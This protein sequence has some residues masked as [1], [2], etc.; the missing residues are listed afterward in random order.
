M[1][2]A[3]TATRTAGP[4]ALNGIWRCGVNWKPHNHVRRTTMPA[5]YTYPGLYVEEVPSGVRPI[6]GVST[7]ETAFINFFSRGPINQAQR[8][9][10]FAD[11][12]RNFGGLDP[13]SESSYAVQQY[14]LN[15]GQV[16]W[17][18]RVGV[19][20]PGTASLTLQTSSPPQNTL[21]VSA[22]NP[23]HWGNRLQIAVIQ[24]SPTQSTFEL[25]VREAIRV[26]GKPPRVVNT[27]NYRNLSMKKGDRA[28]AVDVVN[29]A[30]QLIQL[31]DTG[32]GMLPMSSVPTANGG[33]PDGAFQWLNGGDDG[34]AFDDAGH[35]IDPAGK[36]A[37]AQALVPSDDT[38]KA[39]LYALDRIDPFIFNILCLPTAASLTATTMTSLLTTV[40]NYCA[41]K[42]AFLI[43]DIP[44]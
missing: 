27:E 5:T 16:A 33:A 18:V 2:H 12:E 11:F 3:I 32:L 26:P 35:L 37:M 22:A 13:R 20:D 40:E 38:T 24:A 36:T 9:T 31:A 30:S 41:A 42:G 23:G 8:I 15:G 4:A 10:S 44:S 28:N 6:A 21:T 1:P 17:I 14:Y 29:A 19:G 7:A 39:G 25:F 43:I 34:N